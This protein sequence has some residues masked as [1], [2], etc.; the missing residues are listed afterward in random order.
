MK[1]ALSA[2]L[3]FALLQAQTPAPQ[4]PLPTFRTGIDIVELDV[5]VLDKDR[6][7]V[8]GLTADD[9][10]ILDQGKPQQ[11][12][13]FS[14]VDVPAPVSYPAAWMREAPIDVVSNVEKR[15]LVTIVMDDA[16]TEFNPDFTKRAKEI[17]R[18]AVD[19]LGPADLGAVVFTFMGRSQNFTSDRSRL[20]AAVDSY[21]P[22]QKRNGEAPLPCWSPSTFVAGMAPRREG[23][24]TRKCDSDALVTVAEAL[25]NSSP[26]R[27]VVI[28]I[29]GAASSGWRAR[30]QI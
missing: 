16:Y 4:A 1:G 6:H 9:F 21:V 20:L 28:F 8:K 17:A 3:T 2:L 29:S 26:G 24:G 15:R 13:A 14:A 7:P 19:E 5:T 30:R 22:K 11:I 25:S 27:K 23:T 12:V 10:T 18:N